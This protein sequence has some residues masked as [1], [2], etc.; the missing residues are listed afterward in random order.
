MALLSAC[1]KV[2]RKHVVEIHHSFT[3]PDSVATSRR[4]FSRQL[5]LLVKGVVVETMVKLPLLP[6]SSSSCDLQLSLHSS[7]F[8][9]QHHRIPPILCVVFLKG[10]TLLV[11]AV[12]GCANA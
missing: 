10:R 8:H 9:A 2:F 11:C 12:C 7:H 3:S 5:H 6:P 4:R 1:S